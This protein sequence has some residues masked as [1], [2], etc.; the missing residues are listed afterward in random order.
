MK[1][2]FKF[3]II[4]IFALILLSGCGSDATI[5]KVQET[6]ANMKT[7]MV[8]DGENNFFSNPDNPNAISI[9][10]SSQVQ[11]AIDNVAASNDVQKRYRAL[12]YQQ[13]IIYHSSYYL[14]HLL[15]KATTNYLKIYF[16]SD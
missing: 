16:F 3:L 14:H 8:I 6:Y 12:Y 4:P 1:K 13:T 10:Y 7:A 9:K 5:S 11:R 15:K 2:Y